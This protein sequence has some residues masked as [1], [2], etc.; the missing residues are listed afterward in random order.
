ML[1]KCCHNDNKEL[2]L[3]PLDAATDSSGKI[4]LLPQ[5]ADPLHFWRDN[6][7]SSFVQPPL[8][9]VATVSAVLATEAIMRTSVE[10]HQVAYAGLE[11]WNLY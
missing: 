3:V 6:S 9:L 5:D 2:V 7:V 4:P 11:R 8:P 10:Q 1:L